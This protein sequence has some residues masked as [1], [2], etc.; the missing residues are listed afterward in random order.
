MR[1]ILFV[2]SFLFFSSS[3]FSQELKLTTTGKQKIY[4]I[5]KACEG[6]ENDDFCT[7]LALDKYIQDSIDVTV[8][9]DS[10]TEPVKVLVMF[11][12]EK[13]GSIRTAE[14]LKGINE[15][16]N[17]EAIRV[18][19]S[20]PEFLPVIDAGATIRFKTTYYVE[21]NPAEQPKEVLIKELIKEEE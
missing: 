4:P 14:I 15:D 10:I 21:F 12:I 17:A 20:I 13:D 7:Q 11:S 6:A 3:L 1:I 5:F 8:L 18:I 9:G 19:K 2:F 16:V